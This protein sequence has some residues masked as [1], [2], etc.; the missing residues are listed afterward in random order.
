MQAASG[1]AAVCR[2]RGGEG[3]RGAPSATTAAQRRAAT[4]VRSPPPPPSP[5]R[6]PSRA[7]RGTR[8]RA[9]FARARAAPK[10]A[11]PNA[12][13]INV[14][15]GAVV[16]ADPH[17]G[18]VHAQRRRARRRGPPASTARAPPSSRAAAA[19]FARIRTALKRPARAVLRDELANGDGS[20]VQRSSRCPGA[21]GDVAVPSFRASSRPAASRFRAAASRP[22]AVVGSNWKAE[23]VAE[24]EVLRRREAAAARKLVAPA[25]RPARVRGAR[26]PTARPRRA[27]AAATFRAAESGVVDRVRRSGV[28][29][30]IASAAPARA[31]AARRARPFIDGRTQ[32]A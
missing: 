11:R 1:R 28:A 22:A 24:R 20:V 17:I 6:A 5:P 30:G 4:A 18:A 9:A 8:L 26:R 3:G 15:A 7:A 31:S 32:P 27:A 19:R 29:G 10:R 14:V 25:E 12:V 2:R 13:A 23:L 21:V 16:G